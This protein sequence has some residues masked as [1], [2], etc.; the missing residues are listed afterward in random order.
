MYLSSALWYVL[1]PKEAKE[2]TIKKRRLCLLS[3]ATVVVVV[4]RRTRFLSF[5]SLRVYATPVAHARTSVTES[6]PQSSSQ[7][8]EKI[9]LILRGNLVFCTRHP[10]GPET[11][12]ADDDPTTRW[13]GHGLKLCL[14]HILTVNRRGLIV[15]VV[16]AAEYVADDNS[17]TA[18][19]IVQQLGPHEFLVPGLL[20]LHIH[21]PQY[22]YTGTATDRPLMGPDGWLETYTFPA[23]AS[24]VE[25][26]AL[27][28]QVYEGVVRNTLA[29]GTTTAVYFATL[30]EAPTRT[31]VDI[32]QAHG[33]RAL[34]GK[35][36]MD[37]HSPTHYCQTLEEN[38]TQ[39]EAVI[40]YIHETVGHRVVDDKATQTVLPLIL[41]LV[42][43]RFIPTCSPALLTGLGALA[44]KYG[45][46]ITSH[47]SESVDEVAYS[48]HLD[49]TEDGGGGRT[50]AQIYDSHQLLTNQ[51]IMAH[52]VFL[53]EDDLDLLQQRQTAVAHCSLSNFFF[54]GGS[55]PCRH[56][57]ERGNRVGLGTD[58][59]A[60]YSPSLRNASRATVIASRVLQH[61]ADA[62]ARAANQDEAPTKGSQQQQQQH[63]LDYRHAF[64]MATLGGADALGLADR[65]GTF[66]PGY[67]FDAVVLSAAAPIQIFA[68]DGVED[69]FQK[70]C[71]LA[72]DRHV[73]NVYVQ[74]VKVK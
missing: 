16:P 48:H 8:E 55:S 62:T 36:C 7:G 42:T 6:P 13:I 58:V 25:D 67:E 46:H 12:I 19:P 65:L 35:V 45:C 33:Q 27:C 26:D 17:S 11:A 22:A 51:C 3:S 30:H 73:K 38:L 53:A 60:G 5:H 50:D 15:D 10:F 32:V 49:T 31:L 64:Y 20:D 41:P 2:A 1:V 18:A 74:G 69:V 23:E 40:T 66:R 72:D 9:A 34:I 44:A 52:G 4:S 68:K 43:P 28:R 54:A 56:L 61:Q 39:A 21:A 71:N 29:A 24:L 63:A 14:D 57:L 59:G 70:L 47:I 37:R